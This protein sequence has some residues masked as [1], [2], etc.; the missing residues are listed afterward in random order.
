MSLKFQMRNT[1]LN[2]IGGGY[3]LPYKTRA[4]YYNA[5]GMSVHR[6]ARI[7]AKNSFYGR[8]FTVGEHSFINYENFFDC[9]NEIHIGNNVWIG[10]RCN[11]VTSTHEIGKEKQR[12]G[13]TKDKPIVVEDGCWI[14]A[15]VTILPGVVIKKGTV[16]AA[17]SV[18]ISSCD[19][20]SVYA[21]IP[22]RK[23]KELENHKS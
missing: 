15:N 5:C 9:T 8:R 13:N 19:S 2:T 7:N 12:A 10:M 20:D 22:A 21:G 16:I 4:L 14:G 17:G 23:V 1:L 3:W 6:T 18:V 11:F